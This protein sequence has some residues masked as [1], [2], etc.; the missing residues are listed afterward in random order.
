MKDVIATN[1]LKAK[2]VEN[3][4]STADIAQHL[5]ISR[6]TFSAKTRNLCDFKAE[7]IKKL[8]RLLHLDCNTMYEI[9]FSG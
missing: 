4:L 8:V 5:N 2:M 3:N 6:Q 9:F 7:E 1:K